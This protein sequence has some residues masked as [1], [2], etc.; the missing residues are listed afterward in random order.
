MNVHSNFFRPSAISGLIKLRRELDNNLNISPTEACRFLS[1]TYSN[2]GVD[3]DAALQLHEV[4]P[5]LPDCLPK[6]YRCV[7]TELVNLTDPSWLGLLKRGRN[8]L[9]SVVG[10]DVRACF[11]RAGALDA[12]PNIEV[13][14]WLDSLITMAY[15]KSE[16]Q[17]L[18]SGRMAEQLSYELEKSRLGEQTSAHE[19]EWVA[20][21]DN[22]AGYDIR[23]FSFEVDK[24]VPRFIEVK[25]SQ[26]LPLRIILT[27]HEWNVANQMGDKF[28]FH[29]WHLPSKSMI[30]MSSKEMSK[31]IPSDRGNGSWDTAQ[32]N[33]PLPR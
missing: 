28:V 3:F 14:K 11:E 1:A 15:A 20:L 2:A 32:I 19:V 22:S 25:S 8:A 17:K 24:F 4:V 9:F 16:A 27:R 18:N 23:S 12:T 30:E 6:A 31:H 29:L 7:I 26:Q 5:T 10:A 33:I 21:N 13:I